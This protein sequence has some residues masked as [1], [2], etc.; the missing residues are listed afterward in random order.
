MDNSFASVDDLHKIEIITRASM[1]MKILY[2]RIVKCEWSIQ[3]D[4]FF[5]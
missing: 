2:Y 5:F 3:I 4:G 1:M